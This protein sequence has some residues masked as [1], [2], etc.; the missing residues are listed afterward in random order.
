M[1]PKKRNQGKTAKPLKKAAAPTGSSVESES[2]GVQAS[3]AELAAQQTILNVFNTAFND[4]LSSPDFS[5]VLQEVKQ[6]LYNRDFA[7]AFGNDKYLEV[8]AARW[9][10]TRALCYA[11]IFEGLSPHLEDIWYIDDGPDAAADDAGGGGGSGDDNG[12]R[13]QSFG[14][15]GGQQRKLVEESEEAASDVAPSLRPEDSNVESHLDGGRTGRRRQHLHLVSIGGAAAELVSF[16]SILA[17]AATEDDG[18]GGEEEEEEGCAQ[19]PPL[20]TNTAA[21]SSSPLSSS[22]SAPRGSVTLLDVG[23]WSS[24]IERLHQG[25]TTS[26]PLSRYA[27]AAARAA[28]QPL[29]PHRDLLHWEFRQEDVLNLSE[30]ALE[31]MLLP[32]SAAREEEAGEGEEERL[33]PPTPAP[34]RAGKEQETLPGAPRRRPVLVTLMFTLNELYTSGGIARTT[35]FLRRLTTAATPGSLLL[36]VDSPGSYSEAAVGQARKKYPMQWLLDHTLVGGGASRA[37]QRRRGSR[38]GNSDNKEQQGEEGGGGEEEQA[39]EQSAKEESESSLGGN[40]AAEIKKESK[41]WEKLESHDSIWFRLPESL[42]YP[43]PLENM[44]YQMSLYRAVLL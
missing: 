35:A 39:A 13:G 16:A 23:P 4:N 15:Q 41:G 9:S 3:P 22:S 8:Y 5:T 32:R 1:G 28:N 11:K 36:V 24:V 37:Q 2:T 27:S 7:Q 31:E 26:P 34:P 42:Q 10:P 40:G 18:G 12:R 29:L 19:E 44:R 21:S 6:A 33:P 20:V 25:I 43:I 17:A 14:G 38:D 30:A